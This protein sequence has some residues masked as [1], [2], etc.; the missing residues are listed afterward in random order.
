MWSLASLEN[1]MRTCMENTRRLKWKGICED[2]EKEKASEEERTKAGNSF[3]SVYWKRICVKLLYTCQDNIQM[4]FHTSHKSFERF[5][6]R[7][8][9]VSFS[10]VEPFFHVQQRDEFHSIDNDADTYSGRMMAPKIT[11][12]RLNQSPTNWVK[13]RSNKLSFHGAE[14]DSF[15]RMFSGISPFFNGVKS[16]AY[17]NLI[18]K[19]RRRVAMSAGLVKRKILLRRVSHTKFMVIFGTVEVRRAAVQKHLVKPSPF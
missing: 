18:A 2:E 17:V 6:H 9:S 7:Q 8:T 11:C 10:H 1:H 19:G 14:P 3:S 12:Q 4:S 5:L 13:I 15:H 16:F